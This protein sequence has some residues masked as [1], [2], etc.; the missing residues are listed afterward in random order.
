MV[1]P[2]C[3]RFFSCRWEMVLMLFRFAYICYE[4]MMID[5]CVVCF[6]GIAV[7][8]TLRVNMSVAAQDM[9]D[10]LNWSESEKGLVLVSE[11]LPLLF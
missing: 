6:S 10:D 4:G 5:L 8:Y 9:R 1:E 3:S 7:V 11:K 2:G